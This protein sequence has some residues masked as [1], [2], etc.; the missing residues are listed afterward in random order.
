MQ[1]SPATA[2]HDRLSADRKRKHPRQSSTSATATDSIASAQ[3]QQTISELFSHSQQ[4]P[5]DARVLS[6]TTK[7]LKLASPAPIAA[8]P[9]PSPATPLK[10]DKMYSFPKNN[11]VD[12]TTSP[13]T[14]PRHG[15]ARASKPNFNPHLGARKLA[16]KNFRTQP[17]TDPTIYLNQVW[18]KLDKALDVVFKKEKP[19]FSLEELYR[20]VENLCRQGH[21]QEVCN[22]L[23]KR[24]E[25]YVA[26]DLRGPLL[27]RLGNKSV[28]LLRATLAAWTTWNEQLVCLFAIV[29]I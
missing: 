16:V 2:N 26:S 29:Q 6:P 7:R 11:T 21:A 19:D 25:K 17:K 12:L 4:K 1:N 24:S 3:K 15:T 18:E 20:G 8:P 27:E 13:T 28:D 5:L 14:T 9:F 23:Q 10:P 22:R